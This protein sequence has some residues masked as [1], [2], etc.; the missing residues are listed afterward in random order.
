MQRTLFVGIIL[1][2]ILGMIASLQIADSRLPE[3]IRTA[4]EGFS[5]R[6][7]AALLPPVATTEVKKVAR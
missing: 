6:C 3:A 7:P 4:C 2:I 5:P 1:A